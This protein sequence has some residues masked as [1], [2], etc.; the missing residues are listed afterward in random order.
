M[1]KSVNGAGRKLKIS[2]SLVVV[3]NDP[4]GRDEKEE[5]RDRRSS[6]R[7][8]NS[9]KQLNPFGSG[10][11]VIAELR[12][13]IFRYS[14]DVLAE[15]TFLMEASGGSSPPCSEISCDT[16]RRRSQVLR[17]IVVSGGL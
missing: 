1:K 6:S 12:A 7:S 10:A 11:K 3:E 9:K 16:I 15:E 17:A 4:K 14:V 5:S 2:V 8:G 13:K